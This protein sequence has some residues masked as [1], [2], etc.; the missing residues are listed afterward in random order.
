MERACALGE[1]D[2]FRQKKEH[3]RIYLGSPPRRVKTYILLV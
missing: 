3:E 1:F 2:G